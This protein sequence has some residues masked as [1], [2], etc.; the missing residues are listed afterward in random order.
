MKKPLVSIIVPVYN[1]EKYLA[2]CLKSIEQQ[3]FTDWEVCLVDDGSGP[4][5][6]Q[7]CDLYAEKNEKIKV[8]HQQNAGASRARNTGMK[9][10]EGKYVV[11]VDSDDQL[12]PE[13]LEVLLAGFQTHE[14]IDVSIV[15]IVDRYTNFE[16][17]NLDH[18]EGIVDYTEIFRLSLIGLIPA[19]ICSRMYLRK[20][21]ENLK[22]ISNCIYE[23]MYYTANA[24]GHLKKGYL[25]LLPLYIYDHHAGT[26]TT[27]PFSSAAVDCIRAAEFSKNIALQL[28]QESII[29]AAEFRRLWARFNTLDRLLESRK[30]YPH[31]YNQLVRDLRSH[32]FEI[33]RMPYFQ[34][35]RKIAS[36]A[37]L[38]SDKLYIFL[39]FLQARRRR[40][41]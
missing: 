9:H 19:S 34:I 39:A 2:D 25:N 40:H 16:I 20:S 14:D 10:T 3:T 21:I 31:F 30:K 4:K 36:I 6:A 18:M 23:D 28:N 17:N 15:G 7:L 5:A 32:T 26:A 38:F 22:F 33:I 41:D 11:F 13:Y 29:Q 12:M 35:T 27:V 8:V 37:L 1:T 24:V